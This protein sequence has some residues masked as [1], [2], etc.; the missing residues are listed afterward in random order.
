MS[1]FWWAWQQT[2]GWVVSLTMQ[3]WQHVS[4]LRNPWHWG[5]LG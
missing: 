1:K 2:F 3:H 5:T 4:P